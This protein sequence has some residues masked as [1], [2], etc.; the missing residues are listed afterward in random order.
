MLGAKKLLE[1]V[2]K[3]LPIDNSNYSICDRSKSGSNVY[4]LQIGWKNA[5]NIFN[6]LYEE[7]GIFLDRKYNKL[8]DII[9][10]ISKKTKVYQKRIFMKHYYK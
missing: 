3:R 9:D 4:A 5:F 6:W 10:D 2:L 8:K 1:E 7:E